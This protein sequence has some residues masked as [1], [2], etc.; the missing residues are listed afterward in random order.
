MGPGR[1]AGQSTAHR[2]QDDIARSEEVTGSVIVQEPTPPKGRFI[3]ADRCA[4]SKFGQQIDAGEEFT[5]DTAPG[6][7]AVRMLIEPERYRR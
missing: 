6:I 3:E 1:S 5:R 7:V 4:A 2:L